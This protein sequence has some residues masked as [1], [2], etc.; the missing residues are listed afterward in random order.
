MAKG[1]R[2]SGLMDLSNLLPL[3]IPVTIYGIMYKYLDDL[4]KNKECKCSENEN[5]TLL[6]KLV[7]STLSVIVVF[8]I[9][10]YILKGSLLNNL[11]FILGLVSIGLFIYLSYTFINYEK[12]LYSKDC[13][14]S[15][16]IKKTIFRYYLY[17][18][19]V[20]YVL[21]ILFNLFYIFL[22]IQSQNNAVIKTNL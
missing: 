12:F 14:C 6:K 5:R 15:E 4:E 16:D 21:V 7:I 18:G 1:K 11:G 13:K 3:L 9:L 22:I 19:I 8:N 17:M 10:P 2:K 20:L